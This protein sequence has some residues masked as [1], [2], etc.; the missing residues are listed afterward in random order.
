MT[1]S[2][3]SSQSEFHLM[4]KLNHIFV[5][6]RPVFV[7]KYTTTESEVFFCISEILHWPPMDRWDT[8]SPYV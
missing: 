1:R 6:C 4:H 2:H 8:L 3:Q 5:S 7:L